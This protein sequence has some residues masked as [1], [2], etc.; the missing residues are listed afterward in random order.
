VIP[1]CFGSPAGEAACNGHAWLV[2]QPESPLAVSDACTM[3]TSK[4]VRSPDLAGL[5]GH[6]WLLS[7]AARHRHRSEFEARRST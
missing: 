1:P 6:W 3:L 4:R 7:A 5:V 2:P